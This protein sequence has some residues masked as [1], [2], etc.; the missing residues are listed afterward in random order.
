[1]T[2]MESI[3]F[4]VYPVD[5]WQLLVLISSEK[6]GVSENGSMST[7]DRISDR[8]IQRDVFQQRE[9][10]NTTYSSTHSNP[11]SDLGS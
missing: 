8:W 1:M 10:G 3:L 5:W 7:S 4:A 2:C 11:T 6:I 9:I